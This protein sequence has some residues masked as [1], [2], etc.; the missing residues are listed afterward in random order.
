MRA[1]NSDDTTEPE[2]DENSYSLLTKGRS[3]KSNISVLSFEPP[4]EW[5]GHQ[6][7]YVHAHEVHDASILAT[8]NSQFLRKNEQ[9]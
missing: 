7:L 3:E 4:F 6:I 2:N 8:R 5:F 9:W 1:V